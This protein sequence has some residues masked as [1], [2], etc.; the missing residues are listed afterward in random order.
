M[1]CHYCGSEFDHPVILEDASGMIMIIVCP[2]CR[3]PDIEL[4]QSTD[5]LDGRGEGLISPGR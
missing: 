1:I 2:E 5:S 3:S 4:T